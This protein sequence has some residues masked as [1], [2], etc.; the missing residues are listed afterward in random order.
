MNE[1]RDV[2]EE[3]S[4]AID[5]MEAVGETDLAHSLE[6]HRPTKEKL[7]AEVASLE[8][9]AGFEDL[10]LGAAQV[11]S[12]WNSQERRLESIREEALKKTRKTPS[13]ASLPRLDSK[14]VPEGAQFQQKVKDLL[15][16]YRTA[17]EHLDFHRYPVTTVDEWSSRIKVST[18]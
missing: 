1:L 9:R 5:L 11:L 6:Q 4:N 12:R 14:E 3:L 16:E 2:V 10:I 13:T 18:K 17:Q 15:A 7:Q 8:G